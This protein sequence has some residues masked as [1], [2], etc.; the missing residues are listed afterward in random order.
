MHTFGERSESELL[1]VHP[2]LIAVVRRALVLCPQD[3]GVHDGL[4][5]LEEQYVLV[6]TGASRT[7]GSKHLVQP[8]G[9]GHAVDL[10]PYLVGKFR[11]EWGPCLVVAEA[12]RQAAVEANARIRWGGCWTILAEQPDLEVEVAA[13]IAHKKSAGEKPFVDMAHFELAGVT[14]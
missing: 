6:T 10:V 4:R 5:T 13:Y 3:F 14:P 11:W 1:G 7:L 9:F 2:A 12:M 8:D